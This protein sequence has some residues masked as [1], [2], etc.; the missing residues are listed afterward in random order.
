MSNHTV[1]PLFVK[2]YS[3][4]GDDVISQKTKN[5]SAD[6]LQVSR[7]AAQYCLS[8]DKRMDHSIQ[9]DD[10]DHS[11]EYLD[12]DNKYTTVPDIAANIAI[13]M[14]RHKRERNDTTENRRNK[15]EIDMDGGDYE[16]TVNRTNSD[17]GEEEAFYMTALAHSLNSQALSMF[18]Y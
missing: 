2:R 9:D 10:D 14:C 7:M 5:A 13:S 8:F 6:M 15:M 16:D 12:Y 3:V 17:N 1:P 11:D 18:G 4:D